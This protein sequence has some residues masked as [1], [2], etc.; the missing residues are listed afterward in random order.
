MTAVC[1][2]WAVAAKDFKPLCNN[3]FQAT[4]NSNECDVCVGP[5]VYGPT[6]GILL[7]QCGCSPTTGE[8]ERS[9]VL[10]VEEGPLW[11]T[12]GAT[13]QQLLSCFLGTF[14]LTNNTL[15]WHAANGLRLIYDYDENNYTDP[16]CVIN[17]PEAYIPPTR[18][19]LCEMHSYAMQVAYLAGGAGNYCRTYPFKIGSTCLWPI[20][21]FTM[22]LAGPTSTLNGKTYRGVEPWQR[23]GIGFVY[24]GRS[25][26]FITQLPTGL[27]SFTVPG[28]LPACSTSEAFTYQLYGNVHLGDVDYWNKRFK[29]TLSGS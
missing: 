1:K 12:L 3:S 8:I 6:D 20:P 28:K 2:T 25:G 14:G 21:R 7:G 10:K 4:N 16:G 11:A 9:W 23:Y 26:S 19:F 17:D 13:E 15:A 5:T 18:A 22:G 27:C 29:V 24:G